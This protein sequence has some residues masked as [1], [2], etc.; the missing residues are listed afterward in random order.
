MN[1]VKLP[2]SYE[3]YITTTQ[4]VILRVIRG[5]Y[6][7]LYAGSIINAYTKHIDIATLALLAGYIISKE[8]EKYEHKVDLMACDAE[9]KAEQEA[10]K[11]AKEFAEEFK[12]AV[13]QQ[14][15]SKV[16]KNLYDNTGKI[17]ADYYKN[18]KWD[19][20]TYPTVLTYTPP[21]PTKPTAKPAP[22]PKKSKAKKKKNG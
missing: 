18:L 16:E 5:A 1:T 9:W 3:N 7:G 20:I 6:L 22:A 8:Y 21:T 12:K 15:A 2:N 4:K 17:Y 11:S 13:N 10:E 19:E 14:D